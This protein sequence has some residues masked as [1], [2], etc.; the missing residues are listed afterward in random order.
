VTDDRSIDA[1]TA[2]V[3]LP[4]GTIDTVSLTPATGNVYNASY[5]VPNISGSYTVAYI[6]TDAYTNVNDTETASFTGD[7]DGPNVTL[8]E[9]DN[10]TTVYGTNVTYT[11]QVN[12]SLSSVANCSLIVDSAPVQTDTSIAEGTQESF[13]LD[14]AVGSHTYEITCT[15]GVGTSKTSE[16]RTFTVSD[17]D[18]TVANV[19]VSDTSPVEG[20]NVTVNATIENIGSEEVT[21]SFNITFTDSSTTGSDVLDTTLVNGLNA[22]ANV[23]VSTSWNASVGAHSLLVRADTPLENGSVQETDESNNEDAVNVSLTV[24]QTVYGT[25]QG[26]ITLADSELRPLQN[27]TDTDG[28]ILVTETGLDVSFTSLQALSRTTSLT[29]DGSDFVELDEALNTSAYPDNVNATWTSAGQPVATR[30]YNV[31]GSTVANVPVV[32]STNTSAFQTGILWD[33][34]DGGTSYDGSQDVVFITSTA[35]DTQGRYGT[36]DYEVTF[37]AQLRDYKE[38]GSRRVTFYYELE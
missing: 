12:D 14:T 21:Q 9:P 7:G 6:A 28:N 17:K 38:S 27:F 13:T 23:S 35:P 34:A 19:T 37:P 5:T 26:S 20:Q 2:N 32:N 3:T 1:V 29:Y 18:L 8:L 33:S 24:Y 36:Y 30:N 4:N 11:Y 25:F 31:F 10:A 15:D 22:G 16:E